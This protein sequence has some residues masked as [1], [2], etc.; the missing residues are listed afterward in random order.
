MSELSL[1]ELI[2]IANAAGCDTT[3]VERRLERDHKRFFNSGPWEQEQRFLKHKLQAFMTAQKWATRRRIRKA[4]KWYGYEIAYER[5]T[6]WESVIRSKKHPYIRNIDVSQKK[7]KIFQKRREQKFSHDRR[8]ND[9][10]SRDVMASC[11]RRLRSICEKKCGFSS[12]AD[13]YSR[14]RSKMPDYTPDGVINFSKIGLAHATSYLPQKDEDGCYELEALA[15]ANGLFYPRNTLH[16]AVGHHVVSHMDG[17]W[18]DSPYVLVTGLKDLSKKHTLPWGLSLVDTFFEVGLN[19]NLHLPEDTHMIRPALGPLPPETDWVTFGN[20]TFYRTSDFSK[21]SREDWMREEH[22]IDF[23]QGIQLPESTHASDLKK[24]LTSRILREKGFIPMARYMYGNDKCYDDE[25]ARLAAK[26][27]VRGTSG[28]MLHSCLALTGVNNPVA[29]R[30]DRVNDVCRVL[31]H[32]LKLK[33]GVDVELMLPPLEFKSKL[34]KYE[35]LSN[36]P[37]KDKYGHCSL[38]ETLQEIERQS[39]LKIF[40]QMQDVEAFVTY[41]TPEDRKRDEEW[42]EEWKKNGSQ[43]GYVRAKQRISHHQRKKRIERAPKKEREVFQAWLQRSQQRVNLIGKL[44]Q[45][46][47]KKQKVSQSNQEDQR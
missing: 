36:T 29:A 8:V 26:L 15:N 16:F 42:A 2:T 39:I 44:L 40:Q 9:K 43:K 10:R 7:E 5:P 24:V 25:I 1:S 34:I 35:S 6:F 37:Q 12:N 41:D 17:G 46:M 45:Q 14:V 21:K 47:E 3:W 33:E 11:M 18:D 19:E 30:V 4:L 23:E 32:L 31:E 20:T 22:P 38:A 13:K 28:Q 27:E